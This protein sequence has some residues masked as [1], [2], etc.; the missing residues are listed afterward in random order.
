M[1]DWR[2]KVRR[3]IAEDQLR[4]VIISVIRQEIA[5]ELKC[6]KEVKNENL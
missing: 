5:D 1:D 3:N 4:K 6:K 2:K